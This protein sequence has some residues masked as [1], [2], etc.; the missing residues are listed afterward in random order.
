MRPSYN[1]VESNSPRV[2]WYVLIEDFK[3][4]SPPLSGGGLDF[5]VGGQNFGAESRL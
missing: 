5:D 4:A 1:D 2:W 3:K